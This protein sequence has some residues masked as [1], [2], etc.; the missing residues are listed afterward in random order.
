M[1]HSKL[2]RLGKGSCVPSPDGQS[3]RLQSLAASQAYMALL[4]ARSG[5]RDIKV[6]ENLWAVCQVATHK[7]I[8]SP[9]R[10][11]LATCMLAHNLNLR[12]QCVLGAPA[13]V[14]GQ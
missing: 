12:P 2:G 3:K 10:R 1:V 5:C 8:Q 14:N 11:T 9:A 4:E 7:R 6:S 13:D